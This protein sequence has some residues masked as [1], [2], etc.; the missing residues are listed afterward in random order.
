MIEQIQRDRNTISLLIFITFL[1]TPMINLW[2]ALYVGITDWDQIFAVLNHRLVPAYAV[3]VLALST[4][5]FWRFMQP[6]ARRCLQQEAGSLAALLHDRIKHYYQVYWGLYLGH[7]IGTAGLYLF[8]LHSMGMDL[9]EQYIANFILL[10]VTLSLI[11]GL[12]AYMILLD[13]YSQLTRFTGVI[14]VQN[15][16]HSKLILLGG[17]LPILSYS[18]FLEYQWLKFGVIATSSL[19][20]WSVLSGVTLLMTLLATRSLRRSLTPVQNALGSS[21]AVTNETLAQL[22]AYYNDEAGYLTQTL[23]KVFQRLTDQ[24]AHIRAIIDN[25]AEGIIVTDEYGKIDTFNLAAQRLFHYDSAEVRSKPLSWLM[26]GI[27]ESDGSP[28]HISG[29]HKFTGFDRSGNGLSLS[30]GV[31]GVLLRAKPV[32]IYLINDISDTEAA[33]TQLQNAE[34]QY[35]DLVETAHDLVWSVDTEGHWTYLN[36]AT[37]NLYGYEP[38]DMVGMSIKDFRHPEH[39]EEEQSAFDKIQLNQEL[40]QFET[41]HRNRNGEDIW[42]SFNA[43][44]K[45]NTDGEVVGLNGTARDITAT[46]NFQN[47]LSYQAEH[48]VLTGLYNRRFFQQVLDRLLARAARHSETAALLYIDLD[49]FKYINDTLGHAAGDQLLIEI[50]N[51]ISSKVR[52]G[53]LFA[54]F[55]GDEFTLLLYDIDIEKLAKAAENFRR[56]FDDFV[57]HHQ[58][59]G[60]SVSCSIGATLIDANTRTSEEVM[61]QADLA[62]NIAKGRG[63]NCVNIYTPEERDEQ[64]MAEDMGWAARIRDM[65]DNNH[66]KLLYQPIVNNQ[67]GEI[68]DHEVLLRMPAEDG[69]TI[70]P[71]GFL[72]AAER[73]GLINSLDQ[74]VI[75]HSIQRLAKLHRAGNC[76]SFSINLS[77]RA[78]E[79]HSLA[80]FIEAQL[81]KYSLKPS[82]LSFEIAETAVITDL[83]AASDFLA[84]LK[85]IGCGCTLDDFGAGFSS[86]GY[87]R[88]LPIDRI[89]IDG[90]V[91]RSISQDNVDR[92][93]VE[94]INTMAK[95][96]NII[97]VA[98]SVEDKATL[99]ILTELGVHLVQGHHLGKPSPDPKPGLNVGKVI[100]IN[101]RL[102]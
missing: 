48:D 62:C 49:Q 96:M 33:L 70:L 88:D 46:R 99:D 31:S 40:Y 2:A 10:N 41:V 84:Q 76:T 53:D 58:G 86:F 91:I 12:P 25:A 38:E 9:P 14:K 87:F 54:R 83:N 89:K 66:F 85:E 8:S 92:A 7:V 34:A 100:P 27:I 19:L 11:L 52:E 21:G 51:R 28:V 4:L 78:I 35:R 79:D 82:Y 81:E 18:L 22:H 15:S 56:L 68:V 63:R 32:F 37:V 60:F 74:W 47:Q 17:L 90:S 3:G 71:G 77:D 102:A 65:I 13:K 61:S 80:G 42:L 24:D 29:R 97:I 93:L 57:F 1:I 50:S 30:V 94:S 44:V 75:E 6:V 26:P 45:L 43:R 20:I 69:S 23:G 101:N 39:A 16:I 36:N 67:S 5:Y 98:E 55:G 59:K 73:F 64:G 95:A 72:P